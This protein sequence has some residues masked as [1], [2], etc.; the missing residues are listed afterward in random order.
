M[1]GHHLAVIAVVSCAIWFYFHA[2]EPT[3]IS[4]RIGDTFEDVTRASSFP[5]MASSD[6]PTH[7]E[8]G[9]GATWVKRPAVIIHFNDPKY[10]FTL[11]PTT[12]AA[13]GYMHNKVDTIA[14][15][16]MLSK[17]SFDQSLTVVAALQSQFVTGAW[18]LD[19]GTSWFDLSPEGKKYLRHQI[20]L[21]DQGYRKEVSLRAPQKYSMT[22]RLRC[23]ARCDSHI[24]LDRY[25]IEI[26]IAQDFTYAIQTRKRRQRD[27]VTP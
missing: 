24:G 9:A 7:D 3:V 23:A 2:P 4:V 14:T 1:K 19:D 11:P 12:F 15:S 21:G 25:L 8:V 20:R 6:I 17:A 18:Q 27:A 5:V 13:I 26:G 16:P 22:F 10:G